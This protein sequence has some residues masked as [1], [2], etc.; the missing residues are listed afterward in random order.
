MSIMGLL[1]SETVLMIGGAL[2][3]ALWAWFKGRDWFARLRQR[4]LREALRAL[5]AA[6]EETYREYVRDIKE[7][8]A[9]GGLTL[10]EQAQARQYARD[11]AVEIAREQGIDLVRALG[12]AYLD[13]WI[14]R[15][16]K[17]LKGTH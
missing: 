10:E 15:I 11:R 8:R 3:G 14:S 7:S 6:V 12:A 5:E 13:L 1:Q 9:D 2:F 16:V 17:K 4:R